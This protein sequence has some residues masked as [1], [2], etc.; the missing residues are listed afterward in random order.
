MT[1]LNIF[2]VGIGIGGSLA[3]ISETMALAQI[4]PMRFMPPNMGASALGTDIEE[5]RWPRE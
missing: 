5:R 3:T 2:E 1:L 4:I